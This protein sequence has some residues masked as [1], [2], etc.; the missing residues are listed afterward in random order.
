MSKKPPGRGN[1]KNKKIIE[2]PT[3]DVTE[4]LQ[5]PTYQAY[6][7]PDENVPPFTS[8]RFGFDPRIRDFEEIMRQSGS[9]FCTL[10]H[11]RKKEDTVPMRVLTQPSHTRPS[12]APPE[13]TVPIQTHP[14]Y[15]AVPKPRPISLINPAASASSPCLETI[16]ETP[17]C[18]TLYPKLE[19][20]SNEPIE[21]TNQKNKQPYFLLQKQPRKEEK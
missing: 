12:A 6:V 19:S 13:E 5:P 15:Q 14:A 9:N 4:P 10:P 17:G 11:P 1:K 20:A 2:D 7:S 16:N 3:E 18:S 8:I 21:N